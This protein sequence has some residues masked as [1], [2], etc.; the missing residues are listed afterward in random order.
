VF[1]TRHG[2]GYLSG[3][4]RGALPEEI[5]RER[6]RLWYEATSSK[7]PPAAQA[8]SSEEPPAAQATEDETP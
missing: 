8:I 2:R 6:H 4:I 3:M 7:E 5:A 1:L